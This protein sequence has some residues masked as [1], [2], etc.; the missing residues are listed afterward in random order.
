MDWA[1]RVASWAG[2]RAGFSVRKDRRAGAADGGRECL[3]VSDGGW[4]VSRCEAVREA[5]AAHGGGIAAAKGVDAGDTK[6]SAVGALILGESGGVG[7]GGGLQEAG[8]EEGV[9][10]EGEGVA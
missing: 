2:G 8:A 10:G 5:E 4:G 7:L 3:E 6:V 1:E 9:A